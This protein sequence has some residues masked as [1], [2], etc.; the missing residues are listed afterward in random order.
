MSPAAAMVT[1]DARAGGATQRAT[2]KTAGTKA[3]RLIENLLSLP[4]R[5]VSGSS[6][7]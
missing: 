3:C 6:S 1:V 7:G 4:E 2:I 5:P